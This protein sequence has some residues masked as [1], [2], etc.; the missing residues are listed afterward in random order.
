[1]RA[2]SSIARIGIEWTAA[3]EP[4][5]AHVLVRSRLAA[6]T[7]ADTLQ[8]TAA[9]LHG[10]DGA[11]DL[12]L[13]VYERWVELEPESPVAWNGLAWLMLYRDP[14]RS[15]RLADR[16]LELVPESSDPVTRGAILDTHAQALWQTGGASDQALAEQ[17]EAAA[18]VRQSSWAWLSGSLAEVETHLSEME[19]AQ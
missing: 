17:R 11:Q 1:M 4:E 6:A 16:A 15:L 8:T 7:E 5:R 9:L 2:A 10:L 19:A 12:E 3:G 14:S 18:L 13:A